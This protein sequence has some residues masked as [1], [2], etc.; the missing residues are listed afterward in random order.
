MGDKKGIA[1]HEN[2]FPLGNTGGETDRIQEES[3]AALPI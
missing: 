1:R 2:P 3:G